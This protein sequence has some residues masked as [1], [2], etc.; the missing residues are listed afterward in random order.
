[1]KL[2]ELSVYKNKIVSALISNNDLIKALTNNTEDFL[3][4]PLIP[5]VTTTIYKNIFPYKIIP[6]VQNEANSYITMAFTNFNL[7]GREFKNG[8]INFYILCHNSL[9]RTS[10][11]FL[12]YD[13]IVNQIDELFNRATDIGIGE[14]K[15]ENMSDF[16]VGDNYI[17]CWISYKV[18]D[19]N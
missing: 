11:G 19:F 4:Q 3:D 17:G 7:Q 15:F 8:T 12:R 10:Y 5:D 1:M 18:L 2:K 6:I 9:L 13:Y 14:L 16:Q